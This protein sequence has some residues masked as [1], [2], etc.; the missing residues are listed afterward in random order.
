MGSS[1]ILVPKVYGLWPHPGRHLSLSILTHKQQNLHTQGGKG[2]LSPAAGVSGWP[3]WS[4]AV[5]S[6]AWRVPESALSGEMKYPAAP[7]ALG[8]CGTRDIGLG[9][10]LGQT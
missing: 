7:E 3:T 8:N 6:G 1:C 2:I 4:G 10:E 5:N 9:A